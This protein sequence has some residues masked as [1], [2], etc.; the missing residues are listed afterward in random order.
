LIARQKKNLPCRSDATTYLLADNSQPNERR[1]SKSKAK[2]KP[3]PVADPDGSFFDRLSETFGK[4]KDSSLDFGGSSA[5]VDYR[6]Q[7]SRCFRGT[8]WSFTI[9][10]KTSGEDAMKKTLEAWNRDLERRFPGAGKKHALGGFRPSEF[11]L[12]DRS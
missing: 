12:F 1:R 10:R 8:G 9:R 2:P 5:K 11:H 6:I 7:A 4:A 3:D